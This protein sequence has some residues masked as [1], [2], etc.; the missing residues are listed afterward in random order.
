MIEQLNDSLIEDILNDTIQMI[1]EKELITVL[2]SSFENMKN[3]FNYKLLNKIQIITE[4]MNRIQSEQNNLNGKISK[5][6]M[7]YVSN[8]LID[9]EKKI[10]ELNENIEIYKKDSE[11][12]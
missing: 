3:D 8:R 1:T 11:K 12:Y 5:Y 2:D 6:D 7:V 10:E 9:I 4:T